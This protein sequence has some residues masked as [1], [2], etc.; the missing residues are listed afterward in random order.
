MGA[1]PPILLAITMAVAVV[2]G[3]RGVWSPCGLSMISA[4]NPFTER[5]RGHRY[6]LT[7][8]WFIFGAVVGGALLGGVAAVGALLLA[9]L[10]DSVIVTGCL[11]V[12]CCLT[13][14]AS[15]SPALS[16]RLPN[17][18]RQVNE[19]WLGRYRRWV[20]ASGFGVQIGAGFAT[21]IM[22]AATYLM[23]VLAALSGSPAFAV[24]V[25]VAFGLVRGSAVL[26][27]AGATN[28]M[29]LRALHARLDRL[30][31]WSLR[32]AMLVEAIAA[33]SFAA[34]AFGWPGAVL[35][36]GVLGAAG[37][38][39]KRKSLALTHGLDRPERSVAADHQGVPH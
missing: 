23:V 37:I 5:A 24:L 30:G 29:A 1:F 15:D 21:Y 28:P 33:G 14:L 6:L 16:F 36:V 20:Y 9:P 25:G 18:P 17:H 31:P 11:A 8:T 19:H 39:I 12:I 34:L 32:A 38:G 22:T 13:A 2:A 7:A 10:T 4:I 26:L 3:A 35:V 27:S